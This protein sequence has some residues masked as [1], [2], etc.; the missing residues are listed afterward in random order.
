MEK[1]YTEGDV[2]HGTTCPSCGIFTPD[3]LAINPKEAQIRR[4]APKLYE[5]L[6]AIKSWLL[7]DG[8][9]GG[10]ELL[11]EQFIKANNLANKALAEACPEPVEGGGEMTEREAIKECKKLW[12][13]IEK[14]GLS[15]ENFLNS[16]AG[17]KWIEKEY[18]NDCPLCSY[19]R[20]SGYK[21]DCIEVCPLYFQYGKDCFQL[22]FESDPP[23][24]FEAVRGLK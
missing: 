13:E 15:K 12:E 18:W 20:E 16:S 22:G 21:G 8:L 2:I 6:K 11:N 9:L 1:Q 23:R 7:E 4:A 19:V 24:F 10:D 5:A 17:K 14:S 3:S